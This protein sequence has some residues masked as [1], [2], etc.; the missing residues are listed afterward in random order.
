MC[1]FVGAQN[2][3]VIEC[4]NAATAG[5]LRCSDTEQLAHPVNWFIGQYGS[6]FATPVLVHITDL[7]ARDTSTRI[8]AA[9]K[10]DL[11]STAVRSTAAAL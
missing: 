7:L 2:Y 3:L 9:G 8:I 11:R 5:R 1:W 6:T 10:L 4:K